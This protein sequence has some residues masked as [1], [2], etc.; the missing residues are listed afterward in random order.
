MEDSF[1]R[2]AFSFFFVKL[3][4]FLISQFEEALRWK[5]MQVDQEPNNARWIGVRFTAG[6]AQPRSRWVALKKE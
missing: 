6:S 5:Q 4:S 2:T 1:P 3:I